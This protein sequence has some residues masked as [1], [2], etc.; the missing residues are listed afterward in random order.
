MLG[1]SSQY[2]FD[3]GRTEF[4][5]GTQLVE[6]THCDVSAL[7]DQRLNNRLHIR[8]KVDFAR[9]RSSQS[10]KKD[11][12]A[13]QCIGEHL[14]ILATWHVDSAKALEMLGGELRIK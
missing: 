9:H 3:L 10:R 4:T 13:L 12:L 11:R 5:L 6:L 1:E 14:L 7:C 2:V 8:S